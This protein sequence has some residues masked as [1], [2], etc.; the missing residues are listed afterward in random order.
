MAGGHGGHATDLALAVNALNKQAGN[1]GV[2]VLPAKPLSSF[3]GISVGGEVVDAIGRMRA[4]QVPIAFVRGVN[5][6]YFIP[7]AAKSR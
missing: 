7:K 3:E 6:I 1:V 2:T 5:P 4:G